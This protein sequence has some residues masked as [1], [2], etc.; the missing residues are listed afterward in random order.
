LRAASSTE[1][2]TSH[3]RSGSC[4]ARLRSAD[5]R[6]LRAQSVQPPKGQRICICGIS[7]VS[8]Q[9]ERR[10]HLFVQVAPFLM[11]TFGNTN[12]NSRQFSSYRKLQ[13]LPVPIDR[14][15]REAA[16]GSDRPNTAGPNGCTRGCP[17]LEHRTSTQILRP[18]SGRQDCA[19]RNGNSGVRLARERD[20][21]NPI[22]RAPE[23]ALCLIFRNRE[24]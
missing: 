18:P 8:V 22:R 11:E 14:R 13:Q 15:H 17:N 24:C 19:P 5:W 2:A 20:V 4:T 1:G 3:T 7:Q 23:A 16:I 6:A 21:V 9:R 12:E 10:T